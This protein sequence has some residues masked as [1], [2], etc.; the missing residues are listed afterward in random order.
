AL[1]DPGADGRGDDAHAGDLMRAAVFHGPKQPLRI[2]EVP[3]PRAAP[4]EVVIRVAACGICHTDLHYID[5]GTPTFK[6]PP[7]ILGHEASG[8]VAEVGPAVAGWTQGDRVLV[9]AV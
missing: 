7:M 2:E 8:T 9:P 1:R 6:K 4:G 5:H 3:T